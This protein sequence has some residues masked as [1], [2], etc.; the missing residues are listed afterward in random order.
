VWKKIREFVENLI[1]KHANIPGS[2][3][4]REFFKM[5]HITDLRSLAY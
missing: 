2:I 1:S 5:I 3:V 4:F